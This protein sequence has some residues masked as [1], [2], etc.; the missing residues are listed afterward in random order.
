MFRPLIVSNYLS[1]WLIIR[2]RNYQYQYVFTIY[3][4]WVLIPQKYVENINYLSNGENWNQYEV[5]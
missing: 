1:V 2:G 3:L 4:L 5:D